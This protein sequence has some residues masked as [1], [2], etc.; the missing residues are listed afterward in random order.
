MGRPRGSKKSVH[1]ESADPRADSERSRVDIYD[2]FA[3]QPSMRPL[4]PRLPARET[5]IATHPA[6]A[7]DASQS[8]SLVQ[9]VLDAVDASKV[10]SQ[11]D[12]KYLPDFFQNRREDLRFHGEQTF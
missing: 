7:Q 11:K 12:H 5:S 4:R 2:P 9:E 6:P 3:I 1:H 8:K 10:E